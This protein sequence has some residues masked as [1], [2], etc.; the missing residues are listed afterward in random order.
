MTPDRR[1]PIVV[2]YR[3]VAGDFDFATGRF[4]G[5][6]PHFD[7]IAAALRRRDESL[8]WRN[9]RREHAFLVPADL[10]RRLTARQR[11]SQQRVV[12][13][14]AHH[15]GA[16]GT[17][18]GA[19]DRV[20]VHGKLFEAIRP[21]E[22][23]REIRHDVT[24]VRARQPG[25]TRTRGGVLVVLEQRTRAR[26]Q[27][28]NLVVHEARIERA[29]GKKAGHR[30]R[31]ADRGRKQKLFWRINVAHADRAL[32]AQH[33]ELPVG[34]ER[35]QSWRCWRGRQRANDSVPCVP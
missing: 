30:R 13:A 29:V 28:R 27:H 26:A 20:Q 1:R 12:A 23:R 18:I 34:A 31:A 16:V 4:G 10:L 8:V 3:R 24:P 9:R 7:Q 2:T 32:D 19:G 5:K 17:E 15:P 11:P 33:H 6:P 25:G 14:R 35:N 22:H 21:L